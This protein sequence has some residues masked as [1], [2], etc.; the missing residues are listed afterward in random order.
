[1]RH[2]EPTADDLP[3]VQRIECRRAASHGSEIRSDWVAREGPLEVRVEGQSLAVIMRTPGHDR[4]LAAGFLLSEGILQTVADVF[5]VSACP[6]VAE[7]GGAVD[8]TLR[9]PGRLD[10]R[11]LVRHTIT[12]GGCGICSKTTL[13]AALTR[14]AALGEVMSPKI[15]SRVV[16]SLPERLRAQ[17]RLFGLTGGI[18]AS[19][20]ATL[21]GELSAVREDVGRHNAV[22]KLL[23]H[24][25]LT[26][27]LP[28]AASVLVLSGRISYELV[29]KALAGGI[30]IIVAIGAPTSLALTLAEAS[31]ITLC[32]FT[33]AERT[34]VY[35]H[36]V[37][38]T[39]A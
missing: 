10:L 26:G 25:L 19:A 34:N 33:T 6:S 8:V 21:T 1:M 18:H 11:G 12:H 17:Q 23:G 5:E 24:A 7:G 35:T 30:P 14:H 4:E 36:G 15:S 2:A 16:R 3:S 27:Q 28:L 9:D 37:R 22:D 13:E 32:G 38:V 29:Q 39:D 31:G 20:L